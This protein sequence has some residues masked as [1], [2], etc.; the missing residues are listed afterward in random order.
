MKIILRFLKKN[1]IRNIR[2]DVDFLGGG[3]ELVVQVYFMGELIY[4]KVIPI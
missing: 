4:N 3:A 1:I 2:V